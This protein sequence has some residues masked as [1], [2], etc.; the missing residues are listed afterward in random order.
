MLWT[1]LFFTTSIISF[2][3]YFLSNNRR[4]KKVD[5]IIKREKSNL[6]KIV[7]NSSSKLISIKRIKS[8]YKIDTITAIEVYLKVS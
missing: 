8:S 2:F 1:I 5:L 7:A 3:H 6:N 4:K